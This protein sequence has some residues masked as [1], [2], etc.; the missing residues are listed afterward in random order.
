MIPIVLDSAAS[1]LEEGR[2]FYDRQEIGVGDYF[3]RALLD[4]IGSLRKTAGAHNIHFGF[5]RK[6][7]DRFPFAIYY[8]IEEDQIRIYA[9]LDMRRDPSW[10]RGELSERSS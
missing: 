5:H 9:I 10:I 2:D 8:S 4:D 6:L 3:L 1:D 7:A